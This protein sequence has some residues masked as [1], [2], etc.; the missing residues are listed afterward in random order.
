LIQWREV[1]AWKLTACCKKRNEMGR[2][3]HPHDSK[4]IGRLLMRSSRRLHGVA[5]EPVRSGLRTPVES[6]GLPKPEPAPPEPVRPAPERKPGMKYLVL[7]SASFA[8]LMASAPLSAHHGNAAYDASKE[9]TVNGVVTEW[10]VANP[11]SLLRF[12]VTD[13]KGNVAHWVVESGAASVNQARGV[14]L[15]KQ[16]LKPGDKVTVTMMVAKNG[17]PVGRI[18]RL[19]LPDGRLMV[20]DLP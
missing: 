9:V 5:V 3:S 8:L 4:R 10:I 14:R 19:V 16:L 12:D 1:R 13:D 7:V 11:H 2:A 15:T 17:Q 18:H 20:N 6:T